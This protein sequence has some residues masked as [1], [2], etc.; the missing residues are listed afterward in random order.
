M[1]MKSNVHKYI[2]LLNENDKMS[3]SIDFGRTD[4]K[5][6]WDAYK[7]NLSSIEKCQYV[8]WFYNVVFKDIVPRMNNEQIQYLNN[9]Y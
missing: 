9:K 8:F 2:L 1:N 7:E 3:F 5:V 6:E 4:L